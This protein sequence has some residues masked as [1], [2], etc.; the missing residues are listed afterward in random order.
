MP[1]TAAALVIALAAKFDTFER[2][3]KHAS[4]VFD[5]EGNKIARRQK[6]LVK[7]LSNW[8]VKFTGLDRLTGL[9]TGL[10]AVG[11]VALV[12][13]S[14]DAAASIGEIAKRAGVTTDRLQELRYAALQGGA[15][16][17]DVDEALTNLN[18]NFGQFVTLGTGKAAPTFRKIGLDAAINAGQVKDAAGAFDFIIKKLGTFGSESQKAAI[19]ARTMGQ[20]VGP[21]LLETASK[22]TAGI[23]ALSAEALN[24]NM[25]LSG[26]TIASAKSAND[27]LKRLFKE[28]ETVG[29]NA[30]AQLAPEIEDLAKQIAAGLPDLITWVEKWASFFGLITLSPLAKLNVEL[31]DAQANLAKLQKLHD[32]STGLFGADV[33]V[34][35][36]ALKAAEQRVIDLQYQVAQAQ[37]AAKG[38]AAGTGGTGGGGTAPRLTVPA[39]QADINLKGRQN[40]A[41]AQAA[42]DMHTAYAALL[43]AQNAGQVAL[44]QGQAGYFQAVR[45]QINDE[46]KA[47][48]QR[49]Q[50]DLKKQ[51]ADLSKLG[52]DWA[53]YQQAKANLE[54][55]ADS[56]IQAAAV[57]RNEK[58]RQLDLEL[59]TKAIEATDQLRTGLEDVGL[60][61]TH[62]FKSAKTAV[63]DLLSEMAQLILKLYVLQPLIQ[64]VLGAPG[65]PGGFGNFL[66]SI[67]GSGLG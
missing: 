27:E 1:D 58:L 26:D 56:Q 61:A 66:F 60:A 44:L 14:L 23:A 15:S 28:I 45:T 5:A 32:Q 34:V 42:L 33:F 50:D 10:T 3:M 31:A 25:V 11:M 47:R 12:Q 13:K 67:F 30:I 19:L 16:F 38:T 24:L 22:G 20:D 51:E 41:A 52:T 43:A 64:S 17:N 62:G 53:G 55:A 48:Y 6:Q 63:A 46:Y 40:A 39:T 49:A 8:P 18:V 59:H 54:Q 57:E 7:D 9:L 36:G 21:K 37:M 65:T 4:G 2:D 29:I 35:P